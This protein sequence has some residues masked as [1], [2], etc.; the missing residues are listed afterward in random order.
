[1]YTPPPLDPDKVAEGHLVK[2]A[3]QVPLTVVHESQMAPHEHL[4]E[5]PKLVDPPAFYR[6]RV[7]VP[8]TAEMITSQQLTDST[9]SSDYS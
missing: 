1:M 4:T 6:K 5:G 2:A 8:F 3:L 9:A 7:S